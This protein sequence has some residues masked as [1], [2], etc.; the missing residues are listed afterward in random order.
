MTTN[1]YSELEGLRIAAEMEKRG[2]ELYR[3][4]KRICKSE[5]AKELLTKL[6]EDERR[7]Q[8]EFER[9]YAARQF[10]QKTGPEYSLEQSACLSAVAADVV[11][12][13]GLLEM[14]KLTGFSRSADIVRYAIQG[15]KDSLTF[16]GELLEHADDE[17]AR[18]VFEEI[19]RQERG[20]LAALMNMLKGEET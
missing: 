16:Y 9:L 5:G 4:A 6:E 12:P 2:V 14:G 1:R 15:E 7:H 20:H 10:T 3:H 17:D 18:S 19:I 8:A 11:F 13:G